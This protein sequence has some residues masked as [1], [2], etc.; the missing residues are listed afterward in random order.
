MFLSNEVTQNFT[1]RS[2]D[3]TRDGVIDDADLLRLLS[4]FGQ[5]GTNLPEDLN[6]DGVVDHA[7][8]LM[9]L[10]NFGLSC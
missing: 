7:D 9:I 6:S 4:A 5:R 1:L 8:L 10:F 3:I 2:G